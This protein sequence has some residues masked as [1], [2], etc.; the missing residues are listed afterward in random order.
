M[1]KAV[2]AAAVVAAYKMLTR[3]ML[4]RI[5]PLTTAAPAHHKLAAAAGF[6]AAW[7]AQIPARMT[8]VRTTLPEMAAQVH[9]KR[10]AV[11]TGA[12]TAV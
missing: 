6:R 2:N 3:A 8:P 12:S 9:R 10:A 5:M 4:V 11:A 7:W 1:L